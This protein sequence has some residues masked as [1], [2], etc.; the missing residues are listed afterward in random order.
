MPQRNI[1][2]MKH[3][4]VFATQNDHK[5]SQIQKLMPDWVEL[6]SLNDIGYTKEIPETGTNLEQNAL[7]KAYHVFSKLGV[8]CFADDTGLEVEALGGA[9]GV[10]SARYAGENASYDDNVNLL[11]KNLEGKENRKAS[12]R[13]V[14]YLIFFGKKWLFEGVVNGTILSEKR[15]SSGFGY[16]PIF[17]LDGYDKTFAEMSLEEKNS[18]SH[19][20]LAIRKMLNYLESL[21]S[22]TSLA[23][24]GEY[25]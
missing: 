2:N 12:F 9:P 17:L 11:L 8:D 21:Q 25:S 19:R 3:Q 15:G 22:G 10:Y 5:I 4:L 14:I 23:G 16:D 20:S 18:L 7:Q 13:T 24:E 1:Q 6:K